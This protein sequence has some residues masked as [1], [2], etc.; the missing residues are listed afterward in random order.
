MNLRYILVL[1]FGLLTSTTSSAQI[2]N[3][4]FETWTSG[5]PDS[6]YGFNT[7]QSSDAHSG[8]SAAKGQVGLSFPTLAAMIVT[9]NDPTTLGVPYTG[10]PGSFTGYYKFSPI[11]GS[12]DTLSFIAMFTKYDATLGKNIIGYGRIATAAAAG[13]YTQ[14]TVPIQWLTSDAPDTVAASIETTESANGI[15]TSGT[16][17]EVDDVSFGGSSDVAES[18]APS[19]SLSASVPNPVFS[20]SKIKY[21]LANDGPATLTLYDETGRQIAV[22]ASGFQTAGNHMAIFDGSSLPAGTYYYRLA[23]ADQSSG[24]L[25][26]LIK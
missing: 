3:G 25:L 17:F 9:T 4:G 24:R 1:L 5:Q 15:G 14:F 19:L 10:R 23:T 11:A 16:T 21:S 22:L 20:S 2:P 12:N 7:V 13:T 26:Q 6:W 8:S 18:T